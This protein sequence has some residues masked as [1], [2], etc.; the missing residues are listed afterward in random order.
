ML[1][2][3][4]SYIRNYGL[5]LP[6][7]AQLPFKTLSMAL[8]SSLYVFSFTIKFNF[9]FFFV[10]YHWTE[11]FGRPWQRI[12]LLFMP[13]NAKFVIIM[14]SWSLEFFFFLKV[15]NPTIEKCTFNVKILYKGILPVTTVAKDFF[16]VEIPI[17]LTWQTSLLCTCYSCTRYSGD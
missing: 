1:N 2:K 4:K 9:D 8:L 11:Y 12:L 7:R 17:S 5:L 16:L 13:S 14:S 10:I 3:L 15:Q 6:L